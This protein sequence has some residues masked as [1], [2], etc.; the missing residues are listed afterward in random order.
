MNASAGPDDSRVEQALRELLAPLDRHLEFGRTLL[1]AALVLAP[2]PF[3]LLW[4]LSQIEAKTAAGWSVLAFGLLV[5]I[6]FGWE[7]LMG[8]FVRWR[9]DRRFPAGSAAR[10]MALHVLS[11]IQSPN[12]VEE[13]LRDALGGPGQGIIRHRPGPASTHE[14]L[15]LLGLPPQEEVRPAAPPAAASSRPGGYYDYIPLEPLT[16][17][18]TREKGT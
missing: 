10:T 14:P 11:E 12:K 3:I 4:L 5:L 17:D 1:A 13:K 16:G 7:V 18:E 8:R 15:P 2:A 9:F 6:G